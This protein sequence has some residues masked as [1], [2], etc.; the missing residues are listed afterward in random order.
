VDQ[1]TSTVLTPLG[2]NAKIIFVHVHSVF[3]SI[4]S[5]LLSVQAT[6]PY[7]MA[8]IQQAFVLNN[9]GHAKLRTRR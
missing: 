9:V 5:G 7:C 8:Q 4:Q 2:I 3:F 1:P 6:Q